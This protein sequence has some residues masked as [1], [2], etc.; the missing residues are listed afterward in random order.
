MVWGILA[1][2]A[3]NVADTFFVARLGT[4]PL[5]ALSFTFPVVMT[6]FSLALGLGIG[7]ASV[8][9]RTVGRGDHDEVRRL[10]TDSMWLAM[11]IVL[12]FMAAGLA[13]I[14][15]LFSLLGAG[16]ETL[17][18][19]VAYMQIWYLGAPFVIVPM[20]ANNAMRACGNARLPSA[21]MVGSAALNFVLDPLL[22][23]GLGPVPA[24][25]LQGA[26]IAS[27][28]ARAAAFVLAVAALHYR[29][30]LI[31]WAL[32]RWQHLR[33]SARRVAVIA[34]PAAATNMVNPIAV[35]V[36]TAVVASFGPA[37]VAG[38]GVATRIEAIAVVPLLALTAGL[39]PLIGQNWGA[40]EAGRVRAAM[41]ISALFC[42]AWGLAIAVLLFVFAPQIAGLFEADA[43]TRAAAV[44]Y[45]RW[46][47]PTFAAYG[48][49]ICVNAAFNAV[50]QPMRATALMLGRTFGLFVPLA[51]LGGWLIGLWAVF[52]AAA[53]ANLAMGL[54]GYALARR[55][56]TASV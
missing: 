22:I 45:L 28:A 25:G 4:A 29:M 26:A 46:V 15:P 49:L 53:V 52:A 34:L 2:I 20:I 56:L 43:E 40:S 27:L 35:A 13:T 8:I 33:V 14:E 54:V 12:V 16:P 3:F 30:R 48:V 11:A 6:V 55:R 36:V 47:P 23:F 50:G 21:I 1:M 18:L 42:L 10:T 51:A 9:S 7:A 31:V 24:L 38:F 32:P 37:A 44:T 19:I 17:P 39:G 5:A 41:R